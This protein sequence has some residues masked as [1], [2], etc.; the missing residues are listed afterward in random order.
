MKRRFGPSLYFANDKVIFDSLN[1]HQV[2]IDLIRELLSERGIFVSAHTPKEELAQYFSRLTADYFDH[3]SIASKLGRVA[4]RERITYSEIKET[5]DQS[6]VVN[7]LDTLKQS[8]D[9]EGGVMHVEVTKDKILAL[10]S[11]EHIDYTK[12]DLKQVEPRD[13]IIEFTKGPSGNYVVRST[14]NAF[15]DVVVEKLFAN[16][17]QTAGK[18]IERSRISLEGHA[19]PQV[20]TKFFE[21]LIKEIDGYTFRTMTEAYCY[22]PKLASAISE[23]GDDDT[24]LENQPYV[25]RVALRGQGVNRSFVIDDLYKNNYY[26][27]KVVWQV[28][29]ESSAD[30][31]IFELEAQFSNPEDCTGFSY[32]ARSVII[33]EEGKPTSKKRTPKRDEQDQLF[34]L[35]EQSAKKA[36]AA[37]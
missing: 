37:L 31:D 26:I 15:I 23:A 33:C 36:Y 12:I 8:L 4:R 18:A 28:K 35:I 32:Q 3:R 30:A 7:S 22:K 10:I 5:I 25:E 20:R 27:V 17:G 2:G 21:S 34:R 6:A 1:Q 19:D 13:A 9:D 16:L 24:E 11:Y 29:P 14:Q